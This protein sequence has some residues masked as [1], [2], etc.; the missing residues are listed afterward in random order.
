MNIQNIRISTR[1]Y[2]ALGVILALVGVLVWVAIMQTDALWLQT[3]TMYDHPLQVRRAAGAFKTEV[4][5]MHR[6][7]RGLML[8]AGN[9]LELEALLAQIEASKTNAF[10]QLDILK[11]RY[12]GPGDDISK[13]HAEFVLWNA[14]REETIRLLRQGMVQE[15]TARTMPFG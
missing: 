12:L 10:R 4:T 6:D 2:L 14:I 7:M 9:D 1:L 3:K 8:A 15:A 11:L 5:A 13:L